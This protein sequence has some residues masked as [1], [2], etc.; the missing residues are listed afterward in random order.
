M[1]VAAFVTTQP[2][3]DFPGKENDWPSG[4]APPDVAYITAYQRQHP[5]SAR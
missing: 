2:R 4:G 1:D 3:P 5:D